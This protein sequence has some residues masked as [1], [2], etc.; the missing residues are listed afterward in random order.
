MAQSI[1][2]TSPTPV[3]VP[4]R[5]DKHD[6]DV[7]VFVF[8]LDAQELA[9]ATPRATSRVAAVFVDRQHSPGSYKTRR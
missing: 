6:E 7:L 8:V 9:T 5:E 1:T 3:L 2:R 4:L